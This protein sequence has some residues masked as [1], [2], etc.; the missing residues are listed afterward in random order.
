RRD[1][2]R[3]AAHRAG[4]VDEQRDDRIAE[5]GVL[6][7]LERQRLLRINDD[8][9][10]AR[11]IEQT[12]L[13]VELPRPVLFR[14]QTPLQPVGEARNDALEIR[15]LLVEIGAQ[16]RKFLGIAE[17]FSADRLVEFRRIGFVVGRAVLAIGGLRRTPGFGGFLGIRLVGFI[18]LIAGRA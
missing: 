9:R 13:E 3:S 10:Q 1:R 12:F 4:I 6:L 11:G 14:L 15:Q 2:N 16:A 18:V 17:F 5:I 8:A 7:A